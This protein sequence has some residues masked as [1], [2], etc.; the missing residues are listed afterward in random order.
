MF[1]HQ[2]RCEAGPGGEKSGVNGLGPGMHYWAESTSVEVL[3]QICLGSHF[4]CAAGEGVKCLGGNRRG[5][6]DIYVIESSAG[7]SL[8]SDGGVVISHLEMAVVEHSSEV[9]VVELA[10]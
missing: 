4:V 8:T 5:L 7:V 10:Y 6:R 2:L 9:A 1:A 3:D